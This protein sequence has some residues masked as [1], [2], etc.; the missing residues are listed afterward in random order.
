MRD[1]ANIAPSIPFLAN[2]SASGLDQIHDRFLSEVKF[3]E[4]NSIQRGGY[5]EPNVQLTI[6]EARIMAANLNRA[7]HLLRKVAE[8]TL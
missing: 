2:A 6:D 3:L 1:F 7:A 5:P 4:R 8:G